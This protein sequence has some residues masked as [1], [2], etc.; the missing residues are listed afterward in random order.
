MPV[1]AIAT[2]APVIDAVERVQILRGQAVVDDRVDAGQR[3]EVQAL[4]HDDAPG[5]ALGQRRG[6]RGPE[7]GGRAA[8]DAGTVMGQALGEQVE[9]GFAVQVAAGPVRRGRCLRRGRAVAAQRGADPGQH[10]LAGGHDRSR[11]D[12]RHHCR[13]VLAGGA[14]AS[15]ALVQADSGGG[16]A[17][18]RPPRLSARPDRPARCAAA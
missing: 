9:Q 16:S 7:P 17:R 3:G 15:R 8:P 18:I 14:G 12:S 2:D 5:A 4:R 1:C 10:L 11:P 13:N 6:D